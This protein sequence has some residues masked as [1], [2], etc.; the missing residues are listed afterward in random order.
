MALTLLEALSPQEGAKV[1]ELVRRSLK[2]N[3]APRPH[4]QTNA[5]ILTTKRG[6]H[7]HACLPPV[8]DRAMS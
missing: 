6:C 2:A 3:S 5:E 4:G 8:H 7:A 1:A